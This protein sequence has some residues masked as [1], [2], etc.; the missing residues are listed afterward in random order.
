MQ[1]SLGRRSRQILHFLPWIPLHC[2][3][4][5]GGPRPPSSPLSPSHSPSLSLAA[6][7]MTTLPPASCLHSCPDSPVLLA[8]RLSEKGKQSP[9]GRS[10]L[11][12][13]YCL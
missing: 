10:R 12:R 8:L 7:A 5:A 2:S 4:R 9:L 3:P 1:P 6:L 13:H 11:A